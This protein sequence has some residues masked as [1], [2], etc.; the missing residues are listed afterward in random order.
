MGKENELPR[1]KT[2]HLLSPFQYKY[3]AQSNACIFANTNPFGGEEYI[4]GK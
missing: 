4:G 3:P 1:N 2:I